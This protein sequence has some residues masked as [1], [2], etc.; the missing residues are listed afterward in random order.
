MISPSTLS[1]GDASDRLALCVYLA[2]R[3][4]IR[5]DFAVDARRLGAAL[6]AADCDLVY[7]GGS[8][9]LMGEVADAVIAGGGSVTG[10]ITEHLL[11]LEVGH[12][13]V[14]NLIVVPDMP[15]RKKAMFDRA[16]GFVIAPGGVGTM[17]EL[18]EVWCWAAL[19]LHPKALGVLN[20]AGYYDLLIGF[21]QRSVDDGLTSQHT[22]DLL[23]V[24]DDPER[25]VTRV[26]AAS[27][28]ETRAA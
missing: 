22:L 21:M 1:P 15:T 28:S 2:S 23:I 25:L 6:T 4:G 18:F 16:D 9:G 11:G 14:T 24:D 12:R 5:P 17:E 20:T 26:V 8:V 10:V 13:S 3:H 19:G 7:G 27:R